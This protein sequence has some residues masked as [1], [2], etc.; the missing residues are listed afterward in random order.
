MQQTKSAAVSHSGEAL[1]E[2]I[3]FPRVCQNLKDQMNTMFAKNMAE[4]TE[5][6]DDPHAA[7]RAAF[8]GM[9]VDRMVDA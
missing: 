3:E 2:S 6:K 9:L 8:S 1:S 5:V 4:D 7:L